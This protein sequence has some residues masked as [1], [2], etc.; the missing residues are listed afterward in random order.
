MFWPGRL[1]RLTHVKRVTANVTWSPILLPKARACNPCW[2]AAMSD[3][4]QKQPPK[5]CCR[6]VIQ[7]CVTA[8]LATDVDT[9]VSI[10]RGIVVFVSF[11][12]NAT[13]DDVRRTAKSVLSVKLC[14]TNSEA[15]EASPLVAVLELPGDVLIV[16]QACLAGKR[17]GNNIQYHGLVSKDK[18]R[19]FYQLFVDECRAIVSKHTTS[20]AQSSVQCGT[21]GN[22]QVL[23]METNGPFTHVLDY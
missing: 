4:I 6:V 20:A 15:T 7:Q 22:R 14:E 17:K 5:T 21:Y 13:E 18:G 8:K 23:S 3:S 10:G 19:D 11:L 1:L 12:E 16:P 2:R 9:S